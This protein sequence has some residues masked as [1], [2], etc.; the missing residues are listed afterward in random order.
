MPDLNGKKDFWR[1]SLKLIS[2]CPVCNSAYKDE[3]VRVFENRKGARLVHITCVDC[4]SYFVAAI[5]A[6]ERGVSTIG[7]ITDLSYADFKKLESK[8]PI[9]VDE[10]IDS[11][12]LVASPGFENKFFN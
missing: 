8:T 7:M 9:S 4:L 2:H 3:E 1:K 6:V 11:H 10:I 12:Q 5:M